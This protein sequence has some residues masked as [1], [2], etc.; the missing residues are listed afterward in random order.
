MSKFQTLEQFYQNAVEYSEANFD[1]TARTTSMSFP[2]RNVVSF[3]TQPNLFAPQGAPIAGKLD[4]WAAGQ[5][6]GRLDGPDMRWMRDPKR[7]PDV[8]WCELNERLIQL[9]E[10]ANLL[11]RMRNT[12]NGP[13]IQGVLSDQYVTFDGH[14]FVEMVADAVTQAGAKAVVA[15]PINGRHTSAYILLPEIQF[16]TD[17]RDTNG[18]GGGAL[19]PG[20]YIS[21]NEIG[22][23]GIRVAGGLFTGVCMNGA[24]FGWRKRGKGNSDETDRS[25]F[26]PHRWNDKALIRRFIA[27]SLSWSFDMSEK[28]AQAYISSY[29]VPIADDIERLTNTISKWGAKYGLT[30]ETQALWRQNAQTEAGRRGVEQ[31]SLGDLVNGLNVMSHATDS[32]EAKEEIEIFAG[33]LLI[34]NFPGLF[35]GSEV[36]AEMDG[37]YGNRRYVQ[38]AF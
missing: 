32:A 30:L 19:H 11:L 4:D 21:N 10:D 24:I 22:R 36:Q 28:A 35:G 5:L 7:C 23:G 13:T 34:S 31:I 3:N 8:L 17:P 1:E 6:N 33:D 38:T 27:N 18:R 29:E 9:R 25:V 26:L 12:G 2:L 15:R 16:G 20:V 37:D 14:E